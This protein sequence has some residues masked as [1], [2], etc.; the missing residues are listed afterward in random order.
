LAAFVA[1]RSITVPRDSINAS[2]FGARKVH[3]HPDAGD[4]LT[5]GTVVKDADY[6]GLV[7]ERADPA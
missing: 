3:V 4:C 2:G 7:A 5:L 6:R 1:D